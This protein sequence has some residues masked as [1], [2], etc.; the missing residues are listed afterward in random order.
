MPA[1]SDFIRSECNRILAC[2]NAA[3]FDVVTS[4][5]GWSQDEVED[6]YE[7]YIHHYPA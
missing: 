5:E 6:F 4:A 7:N 3:G 2:M 1:S